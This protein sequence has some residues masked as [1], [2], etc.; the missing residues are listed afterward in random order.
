MIRI[1]LRKFI[2]TVIKLLYPVK[3]G[4]CF[5]IPHAGIYQTGY[6]SLSNYKSDNTLIFV[7]YI[8]DNRK[9]TDKELIIASSTSD[10]IH[11]EE[12]FVKN[13]YPS[14]NVRIIP[15]YANK[16]DLSKIKQMCMIASSEFVFASEPHMY[17]PKHRTQKFIC[18]SYY[19]ITLKNDYFLPGDKYY[20]CLS[21]DTKLIDI[22]SSCSLINSLTDSSYAGIPLHKYKNIG[23]CRSEVLLQKNDVTFVRDYFQKQVKYPIKKFLLYVPTHRDYEQDKFDISRSILG[24]DVDKK[25]FERFLV[26]NG[27][28]IVA[29]L[30]PKQNAA[31]ISEEIPSG[32]ISFLG[33]REFGLVELMQASD[34][35]ITDYTS[36]YVDYLLLDKPVIFNFY[37]IELYKKERGLAFDPFTTICDGAIFTDEESFYTAV[38]DAF[39][40]FRITDRRREIVDYLVT[41]KYNVSEKT[42]NLVFEQK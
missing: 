20:M 36:A 13:N 30:H 29:K 33:T 39:E 31:I 1:I 32:I 12:E 10:R 18:L 7:R 27:I 23:K 41:N 14:A 25:K 37:D 6:A 9:Y 38:K 3:K 22:F 4:R 26:E 24:F 35:L 8:L 28:A 17:F 11:D 2:Y 40:N 15:Y 21:Q 16:T 42:Y 5:F 34:A 19:P